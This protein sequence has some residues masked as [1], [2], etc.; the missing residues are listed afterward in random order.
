[1]CSILTISNLLLII[2]HSVGIPLAPFDV[3][4]KAKQAYNDNQ[5][6]FAGRSLLIGSEWYRQDAYRALSQALGRCIRHCKDYGTIILMDARH[7][8]EEER[9]YLPK[10]FKNNIRNVD[11][12][13]NMQGFNAQVSAHNKILLTKSDT[14][15]QCIKIVFLLNLLVTNFYV[16]HS[17]MQITFQFTEAG[18]DLSTKSSVFLMK[19]QL[20]LIAYNI[21]LKTNVL[22]TNKLMF[23]Y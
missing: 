21:N 2:F 4:V 13:A 19:H 14:N 15:M 22:P 9:R 3:D 6:R 16:K 1:M 12:K 5:R 18:K 23:H 11:V 10:W 17:T 8:R 20:L 7:C